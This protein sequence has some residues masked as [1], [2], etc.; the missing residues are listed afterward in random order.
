M[1][2]PA[3]TRVPNL[4]ITPVSTN[5]NNGL[6]APQLTAAQRDA[7]PVATLA[8][9]AIIYNTTSNTYQIYQV[10][11]GVSAWSNL[12]A[13]TSG[14][15]GAG[16]TTGTAFTLPSGPRAS[17]EVPANQVNGF[18]YYDATNNVIRTYKNGWQTIASA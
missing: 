1:P 3:I 10:I 11:N 6:Y 9:G 15:T 12:G 13:T 14:A 8:N 7:I 2:K 18:M 5:K 17:V 16:L 4:A